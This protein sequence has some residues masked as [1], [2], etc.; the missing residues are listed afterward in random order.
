MWGTIIASGMSALAMAVAAYATYR[1][2]TRATSIEGAT[3]SYEALDARMTKAEVTIDTLRDEV[4]SL[5]RSRDEDRRFIRALIAERPMG[6]PLPQPTPSWL[7]APTYTP[8]TP[9][10]PTSIIE[11]PHRP[12]AS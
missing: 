2:S 8:Y 6:W 10:T 12:P 9:P 7:L 4:S 5:E 1:G 11:P 3:P